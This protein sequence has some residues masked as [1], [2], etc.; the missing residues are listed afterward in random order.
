MERIGQQTRLQ[1]RVFSDELETLKTRA[2]EKQ[3]TLADYVRNTLFSPQPENSSTL[4]G[5]PVQTEGGKESLFCENEQ[6]RG[7]SFIAKGKS[8]RELGENRPRIGTQSDAVSERTGHASGCA[9][10]ACWRLRELLESS[11]TISSGKK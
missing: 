4:N 9:C 2:K 7:R 3:Q 8:S 1:V 5:N 11:T 6:E 10:F